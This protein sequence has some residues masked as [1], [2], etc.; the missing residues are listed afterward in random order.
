M[1]LGIDDH[2]LC[3]YI[4]MCLIDQAKC[5][6]ISRHSEQLNLWRLHRL[7]TSYHIIMHD[8]ENVK[9]AVL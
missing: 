9:M 8:L 6:S 3:D 1:I 4:H 2:G 7:D 5:N